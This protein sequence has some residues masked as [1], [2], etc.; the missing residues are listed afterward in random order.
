MARSIFILLFILPTSSFSSDGEWTVNTS[1][2]AGSGAYSNSLLMDHQR[3]SEIRITATSP[4]QLGF[5][6]G[7]IDSSINMQSLPYLPPTQNQKNYLLSGFVPIKTIPFSGRWDFRIDTHFIFNDDPS[8]TT[9][10]ASVFAPQIGWKSMLDPIYANVSYARSKYPSDLVVHQVSP[11]IGMGFNSGR[12]WIQW[13]GYWIDGMN[14]SREGSLTN[15]RG[16]DFKLTH[17]TQQLMQIIP[18]SITV[19]VLTGERIYTVDMDTK[20]VNNLPMTNIGGHS[21][22]ATWSLPEAIEMTVFLEESKFHSLIPQSNDFK[23]LTHTI[24]V[25]KTW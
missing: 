17:I 16:S 18:K 13:R 11:S 15:S 9:A 12:D 21:I 7:V 4:E 5:S 10:D 22:S 24:R 20:I 6:V 3:F 2:L 19:G 23:I 8:K 14:A 25:S 1:L